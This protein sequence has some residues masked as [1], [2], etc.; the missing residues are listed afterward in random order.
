MRIKNILKDLLMNVPEAQA[1][2]RAN[3]QRTRMRVLFNE[4]YSERAAVRFETMNKIYRAFGLRPGDWL[5]PDSAALSVLV[6]GLGGE[7]RIVLGENQV[8]LTRKKGFTPS[9]NRADIARKAIDV[10]DTR[11]VIE[12]ARHSAMNPT[13]E[14][15]GY[16]HDLPE[17]RV[18]D[19]AALP[20]SLRTLESGVRI[21]FG[22][23][24]S[25]AFADHTLA[26]IQSEFGQVPITFR[27]GCEGES[28]RAYSKFGTS[29]RGIEWDGKLLE[30]PDWQ[31][32]SSLQPGAD[33]EDLAAIVLQ[34]VGKGDKQGLVVLAMGFMGPATYAS[35]TFLLSETFKKLSAEYLKAVARTEKP[36]PHFSLWSV[37][38]TK[39]ATRFDI[40]PGALDHRFSR[41][42][43]EYR[44][45]VRRSARP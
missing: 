21:S 38:C 11:A 29:R 45:E 44:S 22:S 13:I 26:R 9:P 36:E 34:R 10:W 31:A 18:R 4:K 1:A 5:V 7:L 23:P 2:R 24:L 33:Y 17:Q 37:P 27:W 41:G 25:S 39:G 15:C 32:I 16:S 19:G 35:A 6:A 28:S 20:S 30:V 8:L 40:L 43:K 42:P 12:V 3:I 14:T